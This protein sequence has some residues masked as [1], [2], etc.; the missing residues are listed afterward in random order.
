M[1]LRWRRCITFQL[2][3]N[4]L[5]GP[6]RSTPMGD[7]LSQL[8]QLCTTPLPFPFIAEPADQVPRDLWRFVAVGCVFR[9]G[10]IFCAASISID[11]TRPLNERFVSEHIHERDVFHL[12][13]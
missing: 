4:I 9:E 11:I 10:D 13:L 12:K 2:T 5:G 7:L 3:E 1:G 8:V 6:L